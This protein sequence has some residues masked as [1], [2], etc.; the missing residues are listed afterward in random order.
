MVCLKKKP[1]FER[2]D[3]NENKEHDKKHY[4]LYLVIKVRIY[5]TAAP[6]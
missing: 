6:Y 2:S 5:P 3:K 1:L 4:Y